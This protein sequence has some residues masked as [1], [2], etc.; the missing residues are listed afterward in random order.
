[1]RK[2]AVAL[3][4][5]VLAAALSM[6]TLDRKAGVAPWEPGPGFARLLVVALLAAAAATVPL[7]HEGF[8]V[9]FRE[10]MLRG[11]KVWKQ[12]LIAALLQTLMLMVPLILL[13]ALPR[14]AIIEQQ[15]SNSS[16]IPRLTGDQGE[17]L[18]AGT[19]GG[20]LQPEEGGAAEGAAP[21]T[22]ERALNFAIAAL[23]ASLGATIAYS[24]YAVLRE[25]K[26][27]RMAEEPTQ[28]EEG[29]QALLAATEKAIAEVEGG[30]DPR[31]AVVSYFL[32]L[33]QVL[34]ER[35]VKIRD[36]MTAREI[37]RLTL[38]SFPGL[39][40]RPLER[41]VGMF[42]EARYSSHEVGEEVREEALK[43]FLELREGL[44]GAARA[45]P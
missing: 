38:E 17:P 20:W 7:L 30:A 19:G 12:A 42:E 3:A 6:S 11:R 21:P 34:E 37:A 29:S 44:V 8:K 28:A 27:L 18:T 13:I 2:L 23:L 22:A 41:L 16:P 32:R 36:D 40:R 43:C 5:A 45:L 39:G 1:M 31:W 26:P 14:Q 10:V 35:G 25:A 4:Y 9:V 33:C 15:P 24:A